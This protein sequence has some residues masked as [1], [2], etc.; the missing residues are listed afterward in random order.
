MLSLDQFKSVPRKDIY[1]SIGVA[2]KNAT[3]WDGHRGRRPS[4]DNPG[5]EEENPDQEENHS[6]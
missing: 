6:D 4:T 5:Q 3:D 1:T 2:L